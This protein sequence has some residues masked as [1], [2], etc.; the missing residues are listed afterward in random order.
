VANS[1]VIDLGIPSISPLAEIR[2][3]PD[4]W[5]DLLRKLAARPFLHSEG[6]STMLGAPQVIADN[7]SQQLQRVV[8]RFDE[9]YRRVIAVYHDR[10]ERRG[11]FFINP[12]FEQALAA[13]PAIKTPLPL[14]RLDCVLTQSGEIRVI[15][16]NPVGVCTLHLRSIA[17]LSHAVRRCGW[18]EAASALNTAYDAMLDSFRR[19][20]YDH[21]PSSPAHPVLG[22]LTMPNM[23]RGSRVTWRNAFLRAGWRCVEG[24]P[25]IVTIEPDGLRIGGIRVDLLWSDF[26]YYLGYQY[27]RHRET[28]FASKSGNFHSAH[29]DTA[30]LVNHP[31]MLA[32]LRARTLINISPFASYLALSKHLLSWIHRPVFPMAQADRDWLSAHV[33]RTYD[34]ADRSDGTITMASALRDRDG[35]VLKPCQ[36]GGGHGVVVGRECSADHWREQVEATWNDPGWVLQE[37]YLPCQSVDGSWISLGLYNYGGR[38]GGVT[39]RVGPDVVVS[40]RRSWFI[41][42]LPAGN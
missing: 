25:A 19:Y 33:A 2:R 29:Q 17:Y 8:E 6:L 21:V 7:L 38:L 5:A 26:L 4:A 10:P 27:V 28:A 37:F 3:Q 20:F 31:G 32:L 42:I 16:L 22:I 35:L 11:E 1:P 24:H 40:A 12:T 34:A 41:P 39:I 15:E 23:H 30:A 36:Y 18:S 9:F 13:D 14:S